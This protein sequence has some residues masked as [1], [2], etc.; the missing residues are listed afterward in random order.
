MA[1]FTL[2]WALSAAERTGVF[3]VES[4]RQRTNG[5][6]RCKKERIACRLASPGRIRGTD[7]PWSPTFHNISTRTLMN[8]WRLPFHQWKAAI[9]SLAIFLTLRLSLSAK[10]TRRLT[11]Y[12]RVN[13]LSIAFFAHLF[14]LSGAALKP[15]GLFCRSFR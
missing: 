7:Q 15:R 11:L 6:R 10:I 2:R 5:G 13:R 3:E 4:E 1:R 9:N 8:R 12:K 14:E